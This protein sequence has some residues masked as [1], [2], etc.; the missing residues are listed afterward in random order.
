M[1]ILIRILAKNK[2]VFYFFFLALISFISIFNNN[3]YYSSSFFNSSNYIIGTIF[4]TRSSIIGYFNLNKINNEVMY[5]N[6]FLKKKLL[7]IN[8]NKYN[9]EDSINIF[10]H[11]TYKL[12][13]AKI[14]NNSVYKKNNYFTLNKGEKDGIK[15]DQGVI[16]FNGVIGKIHRVSS[17]FSVGH[18]LLSSKLII[19]SSIGKSKITSSVTWSGNNPE[20]LNVLYVPKHFNIKVGDTVYTSSFES[21]FPEKIPISIIKNID[22]NSN[23]NFID[24]KSN[25]IENFYSIHNVYVVENKMKI[26][27]KLLESNNEK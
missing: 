6:F 1:Q 13:N 23:S 4:Q 24:I 20:I 9:Y 27:Q 26:E 11:D 7:E 16:G 8:R 12:I 5:E 10:K 15:V 18:S 3:P 25:P 19:P 22:K 17:N 21:V 14:I 2:Y